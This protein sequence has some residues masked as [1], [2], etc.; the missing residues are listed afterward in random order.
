M[1]LSWPGAALPPPAH[2]FVE[3]RPL[4]AGTRE[5][6]DP[7]Q[8]HVE[9]DAERIDIGSRIDVPNVGIDLF[10][11]HESGSSHELTEACQHPALGSVER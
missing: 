2:P 10:R 3:R 1:N 6:F 4:V 5:R 7:G 9:E 11:T 8:Q